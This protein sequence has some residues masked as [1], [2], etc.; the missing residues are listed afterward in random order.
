MVVLL[1]GGET[2]F[3]NQ[4]FIRNIFNNRQSPLGT[5]FLVGVGEESF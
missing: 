5:L 3:I 4:K 2:L 1:T